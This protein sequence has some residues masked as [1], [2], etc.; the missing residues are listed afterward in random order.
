MVNTFFNNF[1]NEYNIHINR[2]VD[3]II[4][5]SFRKWRHE[6]SPSLALLGDRKKLRCR[7]RF[8]ELSRYLFAVLVKAMEVTM[9]PLFLAWSYFRRRKLQQ[10]ADI[11]TKILQDNP[12]DQVL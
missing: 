3:A 12:Y 8:A 11:C 2:F 7:C 6:A 9:D 1:K 4:C 5:D 10:C